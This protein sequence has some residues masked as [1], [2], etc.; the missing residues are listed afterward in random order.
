MFKYEKYCSILLDRPRHKTY[1]KLLIIIII[2]FIIYNINNVI[3][4]IININIMVS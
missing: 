3:I 2:F 4:I 1:Y